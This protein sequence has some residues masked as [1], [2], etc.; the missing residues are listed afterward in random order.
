MAIIVV[1]SNWDHIILGEGIV[2][3][4]NNIPCSGND[5]TLSEENGMNTY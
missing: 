4:C 2:K 1:K 3:T 5:L